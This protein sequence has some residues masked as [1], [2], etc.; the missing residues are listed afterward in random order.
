MSARRVAV[1]TGTR[2]EYGL[3][4]SSM[5]AVQEN[6]EL[7]LQTVVTGMHLSPQFGHTVEEVEADFEVD[8]KVDSLLDGDTGLSMAKSLGIGLNGLAEAFRS[9]NPDIVLVLGDRG[10]AFAAAVAATHMNIAVAHVHGGDAMT[11]ATV[12]DSIRHALTKFAHIHF[13]A[14]DTS[15][16]RIRQLGEEDWRITTVGAPGLDRVLAGDYEPASMAL[17]ELGLDPD[18][19]LTLVVQHPVTT[20]PEAAGEQMGETLDAL[21]EFDGQLL[22]V[23][24]NADAGGREMIR[25][26]EEHPVAQQ[27][28]IVQSL[29]RER[30][31]GVMAGADVM[32]GNSSSGIIEAPSFELPVVDIG[33]RQ[34]ARERADN[35]VTADHDAASIRA[36]VRR[37]L[38]DEAVRNRVRACD[39]PYSRGGAGDQ[40]ATRLAEISLDDRLF[41][42][43]FV[44]L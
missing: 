39:N 26:I 15:A 1:V 34:E 44:S 20:E 33:P 19:P 38:D 16:T 28:K 14:T 5:E 29:P 13:P 43:Q 3:L 40:I 21:A 30:Y 12:D 31:L 36:A 22:L 7:A 11:S 8:A 41:R 17:S 2:A 6:D 35:V 42:K 32:V 23:Y 4:R 24:P 37:C 10:E 9:L 25:V 18:R 27:A